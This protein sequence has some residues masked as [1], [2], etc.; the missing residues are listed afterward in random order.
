MRLTT[1]RL[2]ENYC[3]AAAAMEDGGSDAVA[4]AA[5]PRLWTTTKKGNWSC[6]KKILEEQGLRIIP[7]LYFDEDNSSKLDNIYI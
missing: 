4:A 1:S 7:V 2:W 6:W 3:P 5:P